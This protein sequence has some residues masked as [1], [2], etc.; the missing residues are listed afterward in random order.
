MKRLFEDHK[1]RIVKDLNG[2]WKFTTDTE[3]IGE[4]NGY[5][6]GLPYSKTVSVPGVW[7]TQL[8]LFTYEGVCWYEKDFYFDG[9]AKLVFEGVMTE[10]KVWLDGNYLGYHYGGFCQFDFLAGE[11]EPGIHKLVLKVD[12]RF[13]DDSIPQKVVDWYHY[14][15]ITRSVSVEKFKGTSINYAKFDYKLNQNYT[16]ADVN[17]TV[18]LCGA[19][20][21]KETEFSI[22]LDDEKIYAEKISVRKGSVKKLKIENI[23]VDNIKLWSPDSPNLYKLTFKTD[24]DD[25]IDRVGFRNVEIKDLKLLINGKETELRGVNRHEDHPDFGMTVPF[26]QMERD[27]DIILDM[28]CNTI[29][30]SHYPNSRIFLDMLDEKGILFWSEI[31][32][33]GCGFSEKALS[34]KVI[35]K[36]GL[37]MHKEMLKYYF[38]HPS[39]IIWGL[40]NEIRTH[41]IAGYKMTK[42]YYSYVKD[43]GG[44]RLVTYA[45]DK[46]MTDICFEFCDIIS[47]NQYFGWYSGAREDW[48]S[49]P[50]KFNERRLSLGFADKPVIMSEFGAAATYGNHTFGDVKWTEEY[51]AKLHEIALQTFHDCPYMIGSYIWQFCDTVSAKDVAKARTLNNK[52]ILNEYR[53]P[54][55]AYYSV[56]NKYTS[57]KAEEQ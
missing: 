20:K 9:F 3:N 26:A 16:S 31:P 54:K 52:G 30:G 23:T 25:L 4:E 17:F 36:R 53:K 24:T 12:N 2:A 43:N 35:I 44:N 14:G 11:L 56:K 32:I 49:F 1:I 47:I 38:N 40:H 33:W 10:C 29:R 51:Q 13:D 37:D 7:N 50:D 6:N 55:M 8:D 22:W 27:V 48:K 5:M 39:I 34:N 42:L 28:G 46:P 15:G 19:G 45:S 21:Q 41:S 57:F 18:E